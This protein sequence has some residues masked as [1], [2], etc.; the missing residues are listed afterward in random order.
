MIILKKE[1]TIDY[2]M[3]D[4]EITEKNLVPPSQSAGK[5]SMSRAP[6]LHVSIGRRQ[7]HNIIS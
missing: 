6:V 5:G 7:Q 3:K 1:D 4:T 2:F